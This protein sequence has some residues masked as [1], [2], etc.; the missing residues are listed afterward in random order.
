M[1]AS[2]RGADSENVYKEDAITGAVCLHRV[3]GPSVSPV[4]SVTWPP[5]L[6]SQPFPLLS[7]LIPLPTV[8][9]RTQCA[10]CCLIV[11]S[12][13]LV[14]ARGSVLSSSLPSVY[15]LIKASSALRIKTKADELLGEFSGRFRAKVV[16]VLVGGLRTF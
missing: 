13:Q 16:L 11:N 4:F 8:P 5:G 2:K 12:F 7:L 10:A 6:P 15:I 3:R 14:P 9:S 1:T